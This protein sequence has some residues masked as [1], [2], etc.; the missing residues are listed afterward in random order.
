M[1]E[2]QA[3]EGFFFQT[4]VETRLSRY[5]FV[6]DVFFF[7]IMHFRANILRCSHFHSIM[8]MMNTC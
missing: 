7:N 4:I 1:A 8:N 3:A 6:Y 5:Y 2:E